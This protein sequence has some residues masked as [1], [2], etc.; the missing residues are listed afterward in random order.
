MTDVE[1]RLVAN[2]QGAVKEIRELSAESQKLYSTAEK[3]QKRQVGLIVDIEKELD[4]LKDKQRNAMSIEAIT[5]YNQKIAEAKQ[6]LKEYEEAG[7]GS[8]KKIEDSGKSLLDSLGKWALGFATVTTAVKIAKDI[9]AS[10]ET[11]THAFETVV[12]EATTGVG[13]FFKAIASGDWTNFRQG[14]TDAMNGARQF[15]NEMEDIENRKNEQIVLSAEATKQIAE[16]RMGTFDKGIENNEK[17]IENTKQIIEIQKKDFA[18]Q[19]LIAKDTYETTLKNAATQ[20]GVAKDKLESLIIEYTYNKDN[21]ELGEK[22]LIIQTRLNAARGVPNNQARIKEITAE[23]AALGKEAEAASLVA[24]DWGKVDKESRNQLAQLKATQIALEGQAKIGSRR[25][26]NL[27]AAAINKKE[28]DEKKNAKE[29]ADIKKKAD[30]DKLK[31][32]KEYQKAALLLADKLDKSNINSLTGVDKLKAVRDFGIKEIKEIRDNLAK[33]GPVTDEQMAMLETLAQ[34]VW[35]TY[36]DELEKIAKNGPV[37]VRF[38][39]VEIG[40][41]KYL[42]SQL[43]TLKSKT[44]PEIN[45][46]L[47]ANPIGGFITL[48]QKTLDQQITIVEDKLRELEKQNVNITVEFKKSVSDALKE[49][50]PELE[51]LQKMP[52]EVKTS[53][54]SKSIWTLMGIDI[55]TDEGK[56]MVDA[57]KSTADQLKGVMDDLFQRKVDDAQRNRE[58]LDTKIAESQRELEGEQDLMREGYAN[59]V[60]LKKKEIEDLKKQREKAL[61]DEEKAIQR[62]R[63]MDAISQTIALTTSVANIF[64]AN[65]KAGVVGIVLAIAAVAAM[66]AAFASAKSS[67][68]SSVKLARGGTG[69]VSG[70]TH[71]QGGERFLDHVEVERGE[72]WGVLSGSASRKYGTPF[73]ELVEAFNKDDRKMIFSSFNKIN[74]QLIGS[75]VNKVIVD[76]SGQHKRLDKVNA[77]LERLNRQKEEIIETGNATII[78]KGHTKKIIHH[79]MR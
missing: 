48:D 59:N 40:N 24:I 44:L 30:E 62:Q 15:M 78:I 38:I 37:E 50:I 5:K 1:L 35:K 55:E 28:A 66:I 4:K 29:I 8:N 54:P 21:I 10:T 20:N 9:I 36:K 70:L 2:N 49:G 27:L 75:N 6:A 60:D 32:Q 45:K 79:G 25:D 46:I 74:P 71:S 64:K 23:L 7:V 11:T 47:A 72:D 18:N 67:I 34:N 53:K 43:K 19:A 41:Q 13:Y 58:L 51:G 52:K 17:L 31:Q 3:Q 39:D 77:N 14:L 26:E 12:A 22:Y 69:T 56:Q 33:L 61:K 76:N 42:Q 65:S 16:L 63:T 68:S 73:R 57:A